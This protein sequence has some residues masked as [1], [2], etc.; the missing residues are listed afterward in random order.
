[1][2]VIKGILLG[3]LLILPASA[4]DIM[5]QLEMEIGKS[6]DAS[7][8]KQYK[9][10]ND[11][12]LTAY[13]SRLGMEMVNNSTRKKL[14]YKFTVLAEDNVVNAFAGP[15]GYIYITTGL[16]KL[17]DNN[18]EV[19]GV[20][21]HEVA[22]V[23][24]H[25]QMDALGLGVGLATLATLATGSSPEMIQAGV[26]ISLGLIQNGYSRKDEKEADLS[27]VDYLVGAQMN[28]SAMW[29]LFEKMKAKLGDVKGIEIYFSSHPSTEQRISDIKAKVFKMDVKKVGDFPLY[30][31]E[32]KQNI[33]SHLSKTTKK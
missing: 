4:A 22:H 28:P 31:D 25:D 12:T 15:G 19:C 27:A 5:D 30:E 23:A 7:I 21:A 1:M 11:T 8:R 10:S 9:V 18:A 13:I 20:L 2:K 26:D 24:H 6:T 14:N 16:L 29:T 33:L 32:F 3:L 17:C